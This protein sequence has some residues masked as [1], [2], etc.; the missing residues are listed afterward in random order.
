MVRRKLGEVLDALSRRPAHLWPSGVVHHGAR[1]AV[2]V[3]LAAVVHLLFPVSPVPDLPLLERGTVADR[4]LVARISFPIYKSEED[5][6]R[7]RAEAAATVAPILD[8]DA[9]AGDTLATRVGVF[10]GSVDSA[11]ALPPRVRA[12]SLERVLAVQGVPSSPDVLGLLA[13]PRVR[14]ALQRSLT[15][16]AREDVPSGVIS[17]ADLQASGANQLRLRRGGHETMVARTAVRTQTWLY[18]RAALRLPWDAP[19]GTAELQRVIL[20]HFFRPSLRLNEDATEAA[21]ELARQAVSPI[22]GR[23]LRGE[24]IVTAHE[25]VGSEELQRLSSY[26]AELARLGRVDGGRG[27]RSRALGAFLFDVITL[28]VF[29]LMILIYRPVVYGQFRHVLVLASLVLLVVAGAAI[30]DR[31]QAPVE[32]IPVAVPALVI[33]ALWDGRMAL[34]LALVLSILISG[35]APFL[36]L[37]TLFTTMTGGAAAALA[38][39]VVRRR[40]QTWVF[41]FLIAAAYAAT[42]VTLG[43][44]RS[45]APMDVLETTAWGSVNALVSVLLAMA[46]LPLIEA[47]ARIT[48]DQTLLELADMN[49]PLLKRLAMEAP[50]TYAHSISVANLTEAAARVT[51]ANP[52]LARVGTYYHDVGKMAKP[53]YFI[54][55]QPQ[56]RNPHD[57]LKPATSAAI[58]RGH[59]GEGMR[60]AE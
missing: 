2:L 43:L 27:G 31:A 42:A 41:I 22:A 18:E 11:A 32:L 24:R 34:H 19:A 48:T 21:R 58:V 38:V 60:L 40:S 4:D 6:G 23:V 20:I 52:L 8:Y 56:G 5:L 55:N 47:F 39:R 51:G 30:V 33:A 36:G 10:F 15:D 17:S 50:G 53:Q 57:R 16:A 9:G 54:E 14:D 44:L 49:R 25:Q 59:V 13:Q 3:G 1:L 45:R 28:L 46:L 35:Q 37:G 29:G 7:E 26:R 12:A